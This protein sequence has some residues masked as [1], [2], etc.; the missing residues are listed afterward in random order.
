MRRPSAAWS[1]LARR[2]RDRT[3]RVRGWSLV[4]QTLVISER[5]LDLGAGR[6]VLGARRQGQRSESGKAEDKRDS[7]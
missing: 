3:G 2:R 4:R 6:I 5:V 1:I 7:A